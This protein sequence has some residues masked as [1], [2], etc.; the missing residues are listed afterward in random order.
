VFIAN[1]IG[2][3]N[4]LLFNRSVKN[5][6]EITDAG[7]VAEDSGKIGISEAK[8]HEIDSAAEENIIRKSDFELANM[9]MYHTSLPRFAIFRILKGVEKK[10]L[11]S[12]QDILDLV[13]KRIKYFL[14]EA[15]AKSITKY[16][17]I[18][19]YEFDDKV[20]FET[21]VIDES[22][23]NSEKKKVYQTNADNRRAVNKF[24]RVDSDGEH[25]FAENLDDD[26]NVLLFTKL[27]KGGFVIDTPYGNYSPDW[28]IVYKKSEV[29][30]RL[31]FVVETKYGKEWRDLTEVE[32]D[33][34][35][36]GT[37]HFRAVS[38]VSSDV[39][40]FHWANSY[41]DFKDKVGV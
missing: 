20:I 27:K 41:R 7:V 14:N 24:Y 29:D 10:I 25:D 26:P 15:K 35:R 33:K 8:K 36:F 17:V 3:I 39:I 5:V 12:N 38:K 4:E 13:I 1:C 2:E 31:Y 28:A 34:I 9:I 21:D 40:D 30:I 37:L 6:Y 22:M 23:L 19:G 32:Q 18:N 11:L 16:E